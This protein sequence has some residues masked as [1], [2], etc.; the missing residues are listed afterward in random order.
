M[1]RL[2]KKLKSKFL[3]I[4]GDIKVFKYPLWIVYDP[5]QYQICGQKLREILDLVQPGDIIARGYV[6]YLDGY[7]IPG[8]YSH[9]GVVISANTMIHSVAE[10]V[11]KVDILDFLQC[12]RC[13][14]IRPKLASA[15]PVAI[16]RAHDYLGTK[17]DFSFSEGDDAL[18]CHELTAS[19]YK[20]LKIQKHIPTL[21]G[22]LIKKKEPVFLAQSFI[23]SEDFKV[24]GEFE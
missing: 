7:F 16:D 18:Y 3:T 2:F 19:C 4:F 13:C 6:N 23:E 10:G 5:C 9:T 8:K 15:V 12:D 24:I 22:G 21:F 14:I 20:D 11:C 17:Y 1:K